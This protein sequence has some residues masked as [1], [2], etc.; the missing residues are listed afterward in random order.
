M[1]TAINGAMPHAARDADVYEGHVIPKGATI[2]LATWS[3]NNDPE[4]F[5]DPRTFDPS[6]QMVD[7]SIGEDAVASDYRQRSSW[8]FGAARRLCPGIHVAP[9]VGLAG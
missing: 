2:V 7:K 8:T 3:C 1:P 9:S 5:R 6:R 4:L